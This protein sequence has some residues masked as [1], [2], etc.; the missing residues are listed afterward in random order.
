MIRK[1]K[2]QNR[3]D[4]IF[5]G[6]VLCQ[7]QGDV[8]TLSGQVDTWDQVVQAGQ[9]IASKKSKYYVVNHVTAKKVQQPPMK[10]PQLSDDV[11]NNTHVDIL[12]IGG[13]VVGCA[14]AR[15]LSQFQVSVLLVEKE[16]DLAMQASG[17]NDG[18]IHP[19][20]DLKKGQVK[21]KYNL[22]GNAMFDELCAQLDVPFDRTGQYVCFEKPLFRALLPIAT[23]YWK[24]LGV[25]VCYINRKTLFEK[26]PNLN[27]LLCC[28]LYFPTAGIVC[29]YNL[30]IALGENA[31]ENGAVVSL[32]TAVLD[33]GTENNTIQW[34]QTNR[35]KIFPQIVINAAGVFSDDV[36]AM[37]GDEFFT[38]HPRKGTNAILDKKAAVYVQTIASS[39][40]STPGKSHSKGGGLVRTIDENLLVGPDAVETVYKEDYSTCK[41]SISATF[42]KQQGALPTLSQADIIT[43]F[44]GVRAATYEED[45]IICK[46]RATK[47]IVH[48]AG[49]QSPGLT[50]APAIAQD[51]ANMAIDLLKS[52]CKVDQNINFK[53]CRKGIVRTASLPIQQRAQLIA[54]NPDYGEIVCRC[55]EV[56]RGEVLDALR[57]VIPCDTIDGV[58]RR[59]RPGMGRCQGGFCGPL[60]AKIIAQEKGIPLQQVKKSGGDSFLVL[61]DTKEVYHE[62]KL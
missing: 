1:Q 14:I 55:E 23:L 32:D 19:G 22:R 48:A 56:S 57:R 62:A 12:I 18:M 50:A 8:V 16:H 25:K 61:G 7:I 3:L 54:Q 40:K 37:A 5:G 20:I 46:G 21:Q 53:P 43:Y 28:A 58:K 47:N 52:N 33:M 39:M 15:Q 2:I 45:F 24:W 51:V 30:T 42:E 17:R 49:I 27:P 38:I 26:E 6:K 41:Q 35:G 11:L 4:K 44:T 60:V 36:A 31:V 9:L 34:V 10:M 13:G 29:P 59:V